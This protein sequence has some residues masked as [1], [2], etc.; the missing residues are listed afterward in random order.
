MNITWYGTASLIIKDGSSRLLVDPF[1]PLK[2]SGVEIDEKR[3]LE[4]NDILITHGHL[5]HA[6]MVP[7]IATE[8]TNVYCT[9]TPAK[10]FREKGVAPE[11]ISVVRSG[12]FI[13]T[14][15]FDIK[16]YKGRHIKHDFKTVNSTIFSSRFF[17]YKENKKVIK[18]ANKEFKENKETV[19]YLIKSGR[20]QVFVLGSLSLDK[21]TI[22]PEGVDCLV[23]PFQGSSKLEETALAIIE[24]IKP[25]TVILDHFD[26]TFP[27][28]SRRI[29]TSRF[30]EMAKDKTVVIKPDYGQ[31]IA[32]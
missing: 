30:E 3:F 1:I 15:N 22:Y 21:R 14:G 13:Q 10:V 19:G 4:A 2:G 27:P 8:H 20:K 16:V 7:K 18:E 11:N 23:L 31:P 26:D 24:R 9:R 28:I 5:D 29:D 6:L 12:T 17:K 32:I 25:K